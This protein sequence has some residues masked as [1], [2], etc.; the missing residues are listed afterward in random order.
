MIN[1][2]GIMFH[3]KDRQVRDKPNFL[4]TEIHDWS[5]TSDQVE[6]DSMKLGSPVDNL[7]SN[8]NLSLLLRTPRCPAITQ[9]MSSE[10]SPALCRITELW[11]KIPYRMTYRRVCVEDLHRKT[12][13]QVMKEFWTP[14]IWKLRNDTL[15]KYNI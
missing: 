14:F 13:K 15:C 2:A 6:G 11:R 9:L 8:R 7:S 4:S 3:S 10:V 12:R 1:H 5:T